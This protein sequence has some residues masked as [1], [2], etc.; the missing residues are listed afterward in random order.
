MRG[1]LKVTLGFIVLTNKRTYA[2]IILRAY[3]IKGIEDGGS[4]G[5]LVTTSY[6]DESHSA[7]F[8]NEGY[9]DVKDAI[10]EWRNENG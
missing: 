10:E 6:E 2:P 9:R 3:K 4:E 1:G 8:V 7:V 5:T